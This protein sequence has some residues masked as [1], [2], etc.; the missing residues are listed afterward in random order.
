MR[1]ARPAPR[2]AQA[3]SAPGSQAVSRVGA[4][5]LAMMSQP[6]P[7]R[8]RLLVEREASRFDPSRRPSGFPTGRERLVDKLDQGLTFERLAEE[9]QSSRFHGAHPDPFLGKGGH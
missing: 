3:A 8:P 4:A 6:Q 2:R 1:P 7:A 9:A 5:A